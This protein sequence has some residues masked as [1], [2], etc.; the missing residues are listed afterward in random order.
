MIGRIIKNI[1]NDYT[2]ESNEKNY[3]C[4]ARGKFKQNKE[5]PLVGDIVEFDENQKYILKIKA[6]KNELIR[7]KIANVD[8]A[9][10]VTSVKS[11]D[12]DTTLLDKNLTIISYNNI[13]PIIYFTKLDL[14]D[15]SEKQNIQK[16]ID[17]YQKIGYN[18][19]TSVED[20][21]KK[22][23]NKT[24]VLTGQSGAGKSTLLNKIDKNLSLKTA[25]ISQ[26]LGRGKHTTRHTELF[27]IKNFYIADTPGFSKIDFINMSKIDIR[28]NMKEMFDN[29]CHCKYHDCLHINEDGCFIIEL[30]KQ[31]KILKSRY[32]NY[33]KFISRWKKWYKYLHQYYRHKIDR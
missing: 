9:V 30:V 4:K 16:Y 11:P 17:Y 29:L 1:S 15:K 25:E 3:L 24:V 10:I 12:F 20:L 27:K 6:R 8:V 33:I 13:T 32:E 26:S 31:N 28:D 19:S 23:A 2:I 22:I 18:I 5:T 21:T 7:P 14:L